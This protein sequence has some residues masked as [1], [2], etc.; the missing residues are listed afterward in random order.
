MYD[1][2]TGLANRTSL[3]E[4]LSAQFE[5]ACL[6]QELLGVGMLDIDYFK[7]YN[8]TY[9]HLMGDRCIEAI[10]DILRALQSDRIFCARYGG[11]EFFVL[12][13]G[14]TTEEVIGIADRIN[15]QLLK[16]KI[17]HKKSLVSRYVTVSQGIANGTPDEGESMIDLTHLADNALYRAKEKRRGSVGVYENKSYRVIT[18]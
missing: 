14:L 6:Q 11:D 15:E 18:K 9:G 2:M 13:H 4:Y 8:D 12:V 3:N 10:A 7:E 1:S 16:E 17:P 5:Q